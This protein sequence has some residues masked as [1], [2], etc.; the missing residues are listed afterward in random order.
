[1]TVRPLAPFPT[2]I[3]LARSS[4]FAHLELALGRRWALLQAFRFLRMSFGRPDKELRVPYTK[5]RIGLALNRSYR[6]SSSN[7]SRVQAISFMIHSWDAGR[8]C[9]RRSFWAGAQQGVMLVRS[10][11]FY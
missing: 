8:R 4:N 1:M 11:P 9:W 2:V 10:A 5:S 6:A 3:S 7:G